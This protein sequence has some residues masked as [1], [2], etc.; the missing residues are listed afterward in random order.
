MTDEMLIELWT[1]VEAA[2]NRW[3]KATRRLREAQAIDTTAFE[4]QDLAAHLLALGMQQR[5]YGM[6]ARCFHELAEQADQA[7]LEPEDPK[8]ARPF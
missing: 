6:A 1:K 4:P 7:M 8:P 2:E 5:F 3:D